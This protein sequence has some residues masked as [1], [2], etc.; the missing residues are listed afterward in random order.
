MGS[1]EGDWFFRHRAVL[2]VKK[3]SMKNLTKPPAKSCKI[4]EVE[5]RPPENE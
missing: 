4:L 2:F 1:W 3:S 5:T